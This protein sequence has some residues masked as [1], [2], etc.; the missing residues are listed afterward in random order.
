MKFV[1]KLNFTFDGHDVNEE[2]F[3]KINI[4]SEVIKILLHR[5]VSTAHQGGKILPT[6]AEVASKFSLRLR[7]WL[8]YILFIRMHKE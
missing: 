7:P 8:V 4:E 3:E 2:Q 1:F 5:D 6:I